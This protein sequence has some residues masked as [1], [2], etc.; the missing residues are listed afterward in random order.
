MI[1]LFTFS[2]FVLSII[3]VAMNHLRRRTGER[4]KPVRLLQA[5][6]LAEFAEGSLW[7]IVFW[8]VFVLLSFFLMLNT[9]RTLQKWTSIRASHR[10]QKEFMK[11]TSDLLWAILSLGKW[12][13]NNI[14]R[15]YADLNQWWYKSMDRAAYSEDS[16]P[17]LPAAEKRGRPEGRKQVRQLQASSHS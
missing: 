11:K 5:K 10:W 6:T 12:G 17:V 3:C 8:E 13:I 16:L 4:G 2:H 7:F 9:W 14:Q 15:N 1:K